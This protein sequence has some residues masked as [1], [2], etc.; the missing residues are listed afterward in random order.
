MTLSR[1]LANYMSR[2][3]RYSTCTLLGLFLLCSFG[4]GGT[5]VSIRQVST[6]PD[7]AE[8]SV[9]VLPDRISATAGVAFAFDCETDAGAVC[10]GLEA[11]VADPNVAMV[12]R[13]Y[14]DS[15]VIRELEVNADRLPTGD[16]RVF[17][18]VALQPGVT[19]LQLTHDD[20]ASEIPV[21]VR[22]RL[23]I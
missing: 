16:S 19:T 20:G 13:L 5:E 17:L 18:L 7:H 1:M 11:T 22:A 21:E 9:L 6:P 4:C 2:A 12:E 10:Y 8:G 23:E 3:H 14:L 15:D